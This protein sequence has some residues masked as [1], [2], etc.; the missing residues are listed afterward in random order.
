MADALIQRVYEIKVLGADEGLKSIET[1]ADAFTRMDKLKKKLN[2][3]MGQK[4]SAGADTKAIQDMENKIRQL[5]ERMNSYRTQV[6]NILSSN[7]KLSAEFKAGAASTRDW[8]DQVTATS[9]RLTELKKQLDAVNAA[10]KQ[11]KAAGA[12]SGDLKS[13]T[14]EQSALK[15]QIQQTNQQLN[16]QVREVMAANGSIAGMR[17]QLNLLHQAFDYLDKETREGSFGKNLLKDI[18]QL[19]AELKKVEASTGRFQRNVGNYSSAFN[20][21]QNSIN[22]VSREL[23]ALTVSSQ[24]FFLAISNNLPI[25]AD[26][27]KRTNEH[28][29]TL[30]SQGEKVPGLFRQLT[31]AIFSWGTAL[32]V[33]ITL[34]T[35]FGK[36]IG[37]FFSR[38][39]TGKSKLDAV[40]ESQN[41]LNKSMEES[42]S[43]F[44]TATK[45]VSELQTNIDL[46]KQGILSKTDVLKQYNEGVGKTIGHVKTLEQAEQKL[47]DKGDAYIKMMLLKSA[48]NLALEDAAKKAYEAELSRQKQ[49]EEFLTTGDK[50]LETGTRNAYAMGGGALQSKFAAEADRLRKQQAEK[51]KADAVKEADDEMKTFEDIARKFQTDAAKIAKEN[52]FS[53][54][55]PGKD[56]KDNSTAIAEE[57]RKNLFELQK[58]QKQDQIN[59]YQTIMNS[60]LNMY[61]VRIEAAEDYYSRSR[62]L[63]KMQRDFE[64]GGIERKGR[65]EE[66]IQAQAAVI[67]AK[68]NQEAVAMNLDRENKI[69]DLKKQS[70]DKALAFALDAAKKEREA[71]ENNPNSTELDKLNAQQDYYERAYVAREAYNKLMLDIENEYGKYSVEGEQKRK[72]AIEEILVTLGN[73]QVKTARTVFQQ[74]LKIIDD[75]A[76]EEI[77]KIRA[78]VAKEAKDILEDSSLG[79]MTQ[80]FQI[81]AAEERAAGDALISERQRTLDRLKALEESGLA[82]QQ[83]ISAA[84]REVEEADLAYTRWKADQERG[85]FS[86]ITGWIKDSI[87]NITG[88]F[89]GVKATR[90]QID[91]AINAGV[92]NIKE[93][94]GVAYNA[95]FQNK[96]NQIQKEQEVAV[97]RLNI[98]EKQVIAQAQTEAEKESIRKQFEYK[99]KQA[100]KKS[101]EEKKKLALQQ[102]TIDFGV[103]A[104]K[105]FKDFGFPWGLI[106]LAGLT[107]LYFAQRAQVEAAQFAKGGKVKRFAKGGQVPQLG[108]GMINTSPNIP[109]QPN[110]DNVLATVKTG[111]VILNQEQ[112]RRL[113]GPATFKRI[114]VPGFAAGGSISPFAGA[115]FGAGLK[116]PINPQSYLNPAGNSG[117]IDDVYKAIAQQTQNI[118]TL[119]RQTNERIDKLKVQ[120]VAGEVEKT[121]NEIKKAN[122]IGTI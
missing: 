9:Q 96:E 116:A 55:D 37:A 35:F 102:M 38:L 6:D 120:V 12:G 76:T 85:Y 113:G 19:D 15:I 32:S 121:N 97:Q 56:G 42:G 5:E 64:L 46:A 54:F 24:M 7:K 105:T 33:G 108:S 71:V 107:A 78:R 84:K 99:R 29:Q 49:A 82:T 45:S 10:I 63:A 93:A 104:I 31:R 61:S 118:N 72:E 23:P 111:E 39:F 92:E 94:V 83:E 51:R 73:L 79:P 70:A 98:E 77:N 110:G 34:M 109:A 30:R 59:N 91:E 86:S 89:R 43:A 68:Y 114:G 95:Y 103:A 117:M 40:K 21:L 17:A 81:E 75:Q 87:N 60:E 41:L 8:S 69:F 112:Q 101:A 62:E 13:L 119:A 4:L 1:L 36:E 27:I 122:S 3:S 74:Q 100:E 28:I 88:Y 65:T 106:P 16:N 11:H 22:Q 20:G 44:Q 58:I 57:Y 80:G 67:Q 25:L 26:E 50:W 48:A 53:F 115:M 47:I 2:A 52:G 90:K 66:Q 14:A 18:Q